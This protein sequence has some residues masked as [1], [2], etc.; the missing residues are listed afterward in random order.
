[1]TQD[2]FAAHFKLGRHSAPVLSSTPSQQ[3]LHLQPAAS[4]DVAAS[5]RRSLAE[6]KHVGLPD[7]VDWVA[8]GAVTP[9]KNQGACGTS[10]FSFSPTT[11]EDLHSLNLTHWFARI[12]LGIFDHGGPRGISF[13][14]NW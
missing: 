12:V 6:Q 9:V 7:F 4:D 1:M 8:N 13:Y 3:Q 2:E 14:P 11:Y 10:R 5:V